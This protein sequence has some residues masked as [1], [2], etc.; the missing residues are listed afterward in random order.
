MLDFVSDLGGIGSFL[1]TAGK[2]TARLLVL[3]LF[4]AELMKKLF[5]VKMFNPNP[6]D[7]DEPKGGDV[8]PNL[9]T[10]KKFLSR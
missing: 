6:T 10:T 7:K 1:Y 5:T 2:F 9:D 8:P 3:D 4:I